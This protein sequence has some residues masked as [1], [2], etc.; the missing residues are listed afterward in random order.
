MFKSVCLATFKS[1]CRLRLWFN[2]GSKLERH[3]E[4]LKVRVLLVCYHMHK[5]ILGFCCRSLRPRNKHI[6][7]WGI[8]SSEDHKFIYIAVVRRERE[9]RE[10]G[11]DEWR[12]GGRIS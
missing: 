3:F 11:R 9:R 2:A 6:V 1:M 8:T 7:V 12:E 5:L 10:G 4:N